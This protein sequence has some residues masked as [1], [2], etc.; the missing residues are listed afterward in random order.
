[1]HDALVPA[2]HMAILIDKVARGAVASCVA[3]DK[4][5]VVAVRHEADVLTVRL[6]GVVEALFL[7]DAARLALV[8]RAE[9]QARVRQL[10][11]RERVEHVALVLALIERFFEQ[12]PPVFLLDARVVAGHNG[13]AA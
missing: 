2:E 11:L 8:H 12:P 1:M 13:V 10:I 7:R 6:V 4:A 3:R 5:S 9:R